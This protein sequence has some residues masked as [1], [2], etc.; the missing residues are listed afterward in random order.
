MNF[1][2]LKSRTTRS[3]IFLALFIFLLGNALHLYRVNKKVATNNRY[4]KD[5][6]SL[7]LLDKDIDL[8][9]ERKM[10]Y[11]NYDITNISLSKFSDILNSI[12]RDGE[13]KD[14]F[15]QDKY[16][17]TYILVKS[18]FEDKSKLV[19]RFAADNAVLTGLLKQ[20]INIFKEI[21]LS[22]SP[23]EAEQIE[24]LH[25]MILQ[26][27]LGED[28]QSEQM[29]DNIRNFGAKRKED[30][31]SLVYSYFKR[32]E[33]VANY[34]EKVRQIALKN[35]EISLQKYINKLN[36]SFE[37]YS[38][39]IV[40]K[41]YTSL[42]IFLALIVF[43]VLAIS[44]LLNKI[45]QRTQKLFQFQQAVQNSDNAVVITDVEH[46]ITY[47]N[48][49]FEKTT[50]YTA[51][52]AI[53]QTPAI[54]QSGLHDKAFYEDIKIKLQNREGWTGEFSNRR[55]DGKIIYEKSSI[56]PILDNKKNLEG[57]LAIK[58]DITSEKSYLQE[59]ETKNMEILTRYQIDDETG[60]WSRNVLIDELAKGA[61]GY[62]IYIKISGFADIRFFYGTST[63]NLIMQKAAHI[64]KRFISIYKVEGQPFRIGEDD[65]CIWYKHKKPSTDLFAALDDYFISNPIE[66]DKTIHTIRLI[67][68]IST[69][70]DLPSGDRLLQG[71]IAFY[72]ARK[73]GSLYVYYVANN[74]LEK[75]YRENILTTQKIRHALE[76][77]LVSVH[78]QPIYHTKTK[79]IYSYEVLMRLKDEDGGIMY[80]GEFLE[81][82]KHASLYT[83]LMFRVIS[84]TFELIHSY[85]Q[86]KFSINM[87]II[88]MLDKKTVTLFVE[89]LELCKYPENL[90]VEILE[91]EGIENYD[92][93]KPFLNQVRSFGAKLSIDDFGSGYSNYYRIMQLDIDHIKIDGSIIKELPYDENSRVVVE[94]ILS[95]A[96]R[97]GWEVVAEFVSDEFIYEIISSYDIEFTQGYYLGKPEELEIKIEEDE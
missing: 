34:M 49:A 76:N 85:P 38:Q 89:C 22:G 64:L 37:M 19:R 14:F 46:K 51:K 84:L 10:S 30:T 53:G 24:A 27:S 5:I 42:S 2:G 60:L 59:I 50:G 88:D 47:I 36:Y 83:P 79:E 23:E 78:C 26:I 93:I 35:E 92:G 17:D 25:S 86:S 65:F 95:F 31:Q 74:E 48:S 69:D 45:E 71:M 39:K 56:Y 97:K 55:K 66:V 90:I 6:A 18:K 11:F 28:V 77:N 12:K 54:L 13:L 15:A 16:Y 75:E 94:T 29:L 40:D 20:L 91:S 44:Y 70:R 4:K 67:M 82:A 52:E 87:S 43:F 1:F 32:S 96:K 8:V 9:F 21:R 62:I 57:Y 68:G 33:S 72:K 73:K 81:V 41:L 61:S 58:L 80:P 3:L 7:L 63:A